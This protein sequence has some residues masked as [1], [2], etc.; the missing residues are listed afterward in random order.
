MS[1]KDT[2]FAPAKIQTVS[3]GKVRVEFDTV[4]QRDAALAK[5]RR[6]PSLKSEES[7]R[8]RPL[9]ILKGIS[10]DLETEDIST[11]LTIQNAGVAAAVKT[12]EDLKLR[13]KRRNRN[14]SLFNA[15]LEVTPALRLVLLDAGRLNM[16]HQR[17]RVLDYSPFVQCFKCLQFGHTQSRCA[18]ESDRC[19]HCSDAHN[20]DACPRREDSSAIKCFNCTEYARTTKRKIDAK[21]SGTSAKECPRIHS[22]IERLNGRIDFGN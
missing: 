1:F 10:K 13:F 9:V 16:E 12:T 5:A 8:R 11:I 22:M 18:S 3:N 6:V 20:I 14:D 15:V 2:N 7:K 19:A 4:E 21:H 17:V